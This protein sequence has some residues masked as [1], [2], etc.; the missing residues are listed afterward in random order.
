MPS[1]REDIL[2]P[3]PRMG[4]KARVMPVLLDSMPEHD[5]IYDLFGGTGLVGLNAWTHGKCKHIVYNEPYKPQYEINEYFKQNKYDRNAREYPTKIVDKKLLDYNNNIYDREM[6]FSLQLLGKGTIDASLIRDAK[7]KPTNTQFVVDRD[8]KFFTAWYEAQPELHSTSYVKLITKPTKDDL[9]F[10]DPPY[11]NKAGYRQ[12]KWTRERETLLYAYCCELD[13]RGVKFM[14]TENHD[15]PFLI[16]LW[17]DYN[18]TLICEGYYNM[19]N[20]SKS[21][22]NK[23]TKR[24]EVL[25]TNY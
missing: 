20:V 10:L 15:D 12:G 18:S 22:N 7:R 2:R 25:I 19:V 14:L 11:L 6:L 3:F 4:N 24:R 16:D 1:I 23:H 8:E 13:K 9:V 17:R 21:R 5:T